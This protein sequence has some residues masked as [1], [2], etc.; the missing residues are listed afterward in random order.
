MAI[1]NLE[2]GT[3]KDLPE[4][5]WYSSNKYQDPYWPGALLYIEL[6]LLIR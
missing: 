5:N 4:E 6:R 2:P 1:K 3:K